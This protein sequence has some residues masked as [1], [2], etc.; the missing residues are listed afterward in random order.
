MSRKGALCHVQA[1]PITVL[2]MLANK[3]ESTCVDV[4]KEIYTI[5]VE[6]W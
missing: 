6:E 1:I 5:A 2:I 4:F 3:G